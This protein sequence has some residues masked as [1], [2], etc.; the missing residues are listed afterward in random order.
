ML[1]Y[2]RKDLSSGLLSIY[3]VAEKNLLSLVA[4]P[5]VFPVFAFWKKFHHFSPLLS[6]WF[7]VCNFSQSRGEVPHRWWW[8]CD[9]ELRKLNEDQGSVIYVLPGGEMAFVVVRQ[10]WNWQWIVY[11]VYPTYT[12]MA[13]SKSSQSAPSFQQVKE[14][15]N[16]FLRSEFC[17]E[18]ID[19]SL[20]SALKG[21]KDL[22]GLKI[23]QG[24]L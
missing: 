15:W 11:W 7:L 20:C 17:F 3:C 22:K 14:V 10:L 9:V 4:S 16:K 5:N 12:H 13:G 8:Q 2:R 1:I 21:F 24:C 6:F 19:G 23:K 18:I